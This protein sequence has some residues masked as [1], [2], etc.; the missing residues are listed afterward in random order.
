M[1]TTD[2]S[3]TLNIDREFGSWKLTGTITGTTFSGKL[4]IMLYP[5]F[6]YQL[7]A[8]LS[9]DIAN[10]IDQQFG[11]S[12]LKTSGVIKMWLESKVVKIHVIAKVSEQPED[13]AFGLA[14]LA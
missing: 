4:Q 3:K 5:L 8:M 1:S 2:S 12:S 11:V 9:G 7:V 6:G 10:R 14:T 13:I